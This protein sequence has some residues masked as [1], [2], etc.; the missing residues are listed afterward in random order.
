MEPPHVLAVLPFVNATGDP[1]LD[2][3]AEGFSNTITNALSQISKLRVMSQ[4]SVFR[5]KGKD[6]DPKLLSKE[7]GLDAL[8]LGKVTAL[9]M[10]LLINAELVEGSS[11]WQVWGENFDCEVKDVLEIQDE[12]SRQISEILRLK[13]TGDEE[14]RISVRYTESSPAYRSY[15]EGR[16][17]WSRYTRD[18]IKKAIT[19]FKQAIELD[20]N[21][22]LA[23]AGIVDCY[24][25]LA[26]NY[27]PPESAPTS[28]KA[29]SHPEKPS[30]ASLEQ[31]F[32]AKV[33]LRHEWD[34]KGAEREI[35]RANDLKAEYPSAHQWY[36]AYLFA[37]RLY[38]KSK[39]SKTSSQSQDLN[40]TRDLPARIPFF[41]LTPNEEAQV[42]CTIARE[43][44]DVGNYEAAS[45]LLNRWWDL[46]S[47]PRLLGLGSTNCAD[48]LFTAGEVEGF[49]ASA[50]QLPQGQKNAEFLLGGSIALFE[51]IGS[52]ARAAEGRMELA[53]C[54]Y[55][56]GNFDLGRAT[57]T[58]VLRDLDEDHCEIRC[59]AL[60][61]LAS[62]ERH[63]GRFQDALTRLNEAKSS[64]EVLGPWVTGR[65][66]LEFASTYKELAISMFDK[67]FI[68][69]SLEHY[70]EALHQFEAIGN[71]RFIG[72]TENNLG[73]LLL[74]LGSCS[75]AKYRL[76]RAR[77]IFEVL[78][79]KVRLA[80]VDDTL[81]RLHLAE[82]NLDLAEE[83]ANQ[84][85]E[86]L[87]SGDEDILFS[88][89]L[90]TKGLVC[91]RRHRYREAGRILERAYDVAFRR[92]DREGAGRALLMML[93]EMGGELANDD[94]KDIEF[95]LTRLLTDIREASLRLRVQRALANIPEIDF[96]S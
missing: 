26:T 60:I 10:G 73:F 68:S 43:Q 48:L 40:D 17:H 18:G 67:D 31:H 37:R 6:I 7:L 1:D 19:H 88:E 42:F 2:Y 57:F 4:T 27:L 52:I 69:L 47:W 96:Q 30:H 86:T 22:A 49:L 75:I 12:I 77:K 53:L 90:I 71:L 83:A 82:S 46:G 94:R 16:F 70:Y 66:H 54:Y 34:W 21:Y 3:L 9:P 44:V 79:D 38:Q 85:I 80:Q 59:L 14:K 29:L 76:L 87:Q 41:Q 36:A 13:L 20:P 92:G 62:L 91:C 84:A 89:V 32:E 23:Y 25:R 28:K 39:P 65:Y 45:Q 51:Q 63:A 33:K 61:R 5:F 81:S 15:I 35:R 11:G 64:I 78:A 58:K 72:I 95:R 56:Q 50:E 24:L 74:T 8:I 93:E 55:R